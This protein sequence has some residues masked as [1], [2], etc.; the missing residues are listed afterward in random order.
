MASS[1][2]GALRVDLG[3]DSAKFE[4]GARRVKRPL[5]DMRRQ[6]AVVATIAAAAG[7]AISAAALAGAKEIDKS[8]K[9]A[10]RLGASIGGFRALEL[11]AGDAG[12]S[13]SSLT[14][15]LQT[16]D[17]EIA[18]IGQ[19]G[20]ADRALKALGL[21]AK[22]IESL[23]ADEK[24]ATIADRVKELGLSTGETTAILRD[25]GVRNREMVLLVGAGGDAIRQARKD[26]KDYG[27]EVSQVDSDRIE[28][29]NDAIERLSLITQYLGQQ[30]A[31]RLVPAFGRLAEAM[32]DSLREGG[33]LRI[34][35]D[36]IVNNIQRLGTYLAVIV[37]GF[38]VRFVGALVLAKLATLSLAGAL[39]ALRV[40]IARTGIGILII[41]A[42]E[43]VHQFSR[44]VAATGSFGGA[45]GL[46]KDLALEVFDRIKR[47]VALIEEA[48]GVAAFGMQAAFITAFAGILRGFASL[49]QSLASGF[50][51]LFGTQIEGLGAGVAAEMTALGTKMRAD[52]GELTRSLGGAFASL[53]KEP[54]KT[55]ADL[56]GVVEE[57][58]VKSDEAAA[59]AARL[60]GAL[61]DVGGGGGGSAGRAAAGID[62]VGGA[63]DTA[64]DK[65]Q[66]FKGTARSAFQSFVTGAKSAREAL[67]DLL[68]GFA[69]TLAGQAFDM[70]FAGIFPSAAGNVFQNGS[71]V[72]AFASG[73]I[74]DRPTLFP[75]RGG[76]TGLMGEAG[77]EAIMPLKRGPGGNLGVEARGGMT[78]VRVFIDDNGN[79][80]AKIESVS[81][82]VSAKVVQSGLSQYDREVLPSSVRRVSND[83]RRMG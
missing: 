81:G 32:T 78:D 80:D 61:D 52:T 40:A 6:F 46:L 10:R 24:L 76:S 15:D 1:V 51:S 41:G 35:L 38:G 2:I 68:S 9:A 55:L 37:T 28:A 33:A 20:N 36:A 22:A 29:A 66:E 5:E 12:V 75:M 30:L 49:T 64:M 65:M 45:L 13:L 34:V 39:T 48:F 43:L 72:T 74:I 69:N 67:A 19:S 58:T 8:A 47:G 73:G 44:M 54:L 60:S 53:A 62:G 16:I 4:K 31:L 25:L 57:T 18:S 77:P 70:L 11:A 14:N 27:L 3:L 23:D 50:N 71:P 82:M 83:P 56:N 63:I 7:V 21:E 26:I 17:R 59:A 79:L 42:A